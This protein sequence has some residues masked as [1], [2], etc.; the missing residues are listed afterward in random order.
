MGSKNTIAESI[1]SCIAQR[2]P[3]K[4]IFVDACAGGF[5]ISH[6]VLVNTNMSVMANDLNQYIIALYEAMFTLPKEEFDTFVNSWVSRDTFLDMRDNPQNYDEWKV[7]F[8]LSTWSFG[9]TGQSYIYAADKEAIKKALFNGVVNGIW[10]DTLADFYNNHLPQSLHSVKGGKNRRI[11]ILRYYADY[12]H[13]HFQLENL[14]RIERL[15]VL[16]DTLR[17]ETSRINKLG[18]EDY[19]VFISKLALLPKEITDQMVIY[20]DPPYE[21]TYGYYAHDINYDEFWQFVRDNRK[22]FPIYVSSYDAPSDF[23]CVWSELKM[24]NVNNANYETRKEPNKHQSENL[25]YNGAPGA[26][27]SL[28]EML[29]F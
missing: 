17:A 29:G 23:V 5:A 22:V 21:N 8:A 14:S 18:A 28:A 2:H 10:D 7:G 20:I 15:Q 1:V 9:G 3:D 6:C 11:R 4:H 19:K 26:K 25:Y 27:I 16:A 24:V 12:T 13:S